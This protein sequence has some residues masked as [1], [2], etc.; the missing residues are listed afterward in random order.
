MA[1]ESFLK[2]GIVIL[3]L[4]TKTPGFLPKPRK[5]L[6]G[7]RPCLPSSPSPRMAPA[8][9]LVCL[10]QTDTWCVDLVTSAWELLEICYL[11]L[12]VVSRVRLQLNCV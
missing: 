9:E 8:L 6:A 12:P 11:I 5:A 7:F 2:P 3:Q 4:I 1:A 10:V